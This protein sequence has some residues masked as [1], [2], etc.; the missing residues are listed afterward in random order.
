MIPHFVAEHLKI[1]MDSELTHFA[2]TSFLS[3]FTLG[4]NCRQFNFSTNYQLQAQNDPMNS[5]DES[6]RVF[7]TKWHI[8]DMAAPY[9]AGWKICF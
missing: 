7:E 6:T 5:I 4:K 8:C 9:F 3:G 1:N 2:V